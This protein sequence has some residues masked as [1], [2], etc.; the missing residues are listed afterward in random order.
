MFN[1]LDP[2]GGEESIVHLGEV[3]H[4]LPSENQIWLS[5]VMLSAKL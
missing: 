3:R 2:T 4:F 5:L 1:A